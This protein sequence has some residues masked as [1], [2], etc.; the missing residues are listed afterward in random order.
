MLADQRGDALVN[1]IPHFVRGDGAKLAPGNLDSEVHGPAMTDLHH[2][3]IR[4]AIACQE[5]RDR[6]YGLLRSR[7]AD[8][9]HGLRRESREA[10]ERESQVRAA[11]VVGNRVDLIDDYSLDRL[12]Y[13]P[14]L[15]RREQNVE[16]LGRCDQNVRRALQ[17]PAPLVHQRVAG[18]HGGADFRHEK[19]A[20]AR[21]LQ[22]LAQRRFEIFL[23]VVPESFQ[24]G[25]VKNFRLVT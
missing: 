17:H 8:A 9:N 23:N 6:F 21:Q 14:A 16:G 3:G 10:F 2:D 22:N 19:P 15:R 12:E 1:L 4:P 5:V 18:A 24:R 25:N 11:L 13:F 7:E 20:L